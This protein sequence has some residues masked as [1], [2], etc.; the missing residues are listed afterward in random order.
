MCD[1]FITQ[2]RN[3]LNL[4]RVLR[5]WVVCLFIAACAAVLY[6][7]TFLMRG[8][9]VVW[10]SYG[11]FPLLALCAGALF[12]WVR[13]SDREAAARA[14]DSFFGLKDMLVSAYHFKRLATSTEAHRL[15]MLQA[16]VAV[17]SLSATQMPLGVSR[18]LLFACGGLVL[19]L[20]G[21]AQIPPSAQV[22][23]AQEAARESLAKSE[24]TRA[25]LEEWIDE[26]EA[27]L[28]EAEQEVIDLNSLREAVAA[29]ET[30]D[31][32][33][34][35]M[36]QLARLELQV[37][38]RM[39]T[40]DQRE[41]AAVLQ[42][43]AEALKATPS[44]DARKLAKD[45]EAKA[46]QQAGEVLSDLAPDAAQL[47]NLSELEKQLARLRAVS[48]PM[49]QASQAVK[50]NAKSMQSTRQ[51]EASELA[52]KSMDGLLSD[53]DAAAL[54]M[55]KLV[56][57]QKIGQSDQAGAC[58]A[59]NS[60]IGEKMT[61]IGQQLTKMQA[62]QK[63]QQQLSDFRKL[64][65]Q[66]Q[67]YSSGQVASLKPSAGQLPGSG[68]QAGEGSDA[69][70]REGSDPL[71]EGS[72]LSSLQGQKNEGPSL[73]MVEDAE[74]GSG[75]SQRSAQAVVREHQ[76]QFESFVQRDDIPDSVKFAV[77]H[78]F[79]SIHQSEPISI[80]NP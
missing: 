65:N 51:A 13:F 42:A 44:P 79:E 23:A 62:R 40:M 39:K 69:S 58:Q 60:R 11:I 33:R 78:Y 46:Y 43:V 31:D 12:A 16:D 56:Q 66:A 18:R 59:C 72:E 8:H 54:Q 20:I 63:A 49:A 34:D 38:E 80:T 28:D 30:S 45:L 24:V 35:A 15:V 71:W 76:R 61:Q 68:K 50:S 75:S 25:A 26:L 53:L 67:A 22:L 17:A 64:L 37:S 27:S 7:G 55:E 1:H 9:A 74:S 47:S 41:D 52:S 6:A 19:L 10:Q 29:F 57:Q 5:A 14:A 4:G 21:L 2:I 3:R 70:R 32:S 73:S 48:K 77:S 36:R